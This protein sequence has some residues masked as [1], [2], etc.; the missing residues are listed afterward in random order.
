MWNE[1]LFASQNTGKFRSGLFYGIH[2]C[3]GSGL[4]H[5]A[6]PED[7]EDREV[8]PHTNQTGSPSEWIRNSSDWGWDAVSPWIAFIFCLI[9]PVGNDTQLLVSLLA[10]C[11]LVIFLVFTHF[12]S[13]SAPLRGDVVLFCGFKQPDETLAQE[14]GLEWRLQHRGK[15]HKVLEIKTRLDEAEGE[16]V[17]RCCGHLCQWLLHVYPFSVTPTQIDS[18][19]SEAL[20]NDVL[21][22]TCIVWSFDLKKSQ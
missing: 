18:P 6:D 19:L 10:F 11:S 15:G 1:P 22:E 7:C 3:G 9:W 4:Q 5:R 13:V 20:E 16:T 2:W 8:E 14:V 12:K 21:K 17:G